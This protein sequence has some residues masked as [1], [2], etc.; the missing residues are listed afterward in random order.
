MATAVTGSVNHWPESKCAKA[1]W[2][3]QE[4]PP[5]RR[6]LTDTAAWLETRPGQRWLLQG[7]KERG[8]TL[9]ELTAN[10]SE[11]PGAAHA[12]AHSPGRRRL[13]SGALTARADPR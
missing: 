7:A 11:L 4:L 8:F 5:Y 6:L 13:K 12:D 1:F 2:G 10:A 3:Q 9:H